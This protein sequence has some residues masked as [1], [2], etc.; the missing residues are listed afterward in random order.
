MFRSSFYKTFLDLWFVIIINS[1]QDPLQRGTSTMSRKDPCRRVYECLCIWYVWCKVVQWVPLWV[2]WQPLRPNGIRVG[3]VGK[4]CFHH[5]TSFSLNI[6]LKEHY[7]LYYR[8]CNV[9]STYAHMCEDIGVDVYGWRDLTPCQFSTMEKVGVTFLFHFFNSHFLTLFLEN[10]LCYLLINKTV[11]MKSKLRTW[12]L[13]QM[14]RYR[15]HGPRNVSPVTNWQYC[16]F[17]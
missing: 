10:W 8:L 1:P 6:M 4:L 11:K 2:S 12:L 13:S 3:F 16:F 17:N 7:N 5:K 14:M 15:Y 9:A